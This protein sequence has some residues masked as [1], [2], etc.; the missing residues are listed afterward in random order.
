MDNRRPQLAIVS[1]IAFENLSDKFDLPNGQKENENLALYT[2]SMKEIAT[3]NK[4]HFVNAYLPSKEWFDAAGDEPLTI[5]GSQLT[6]AG[7]AKFSKLLTD[8]IF[9][10]AAAKAEAHR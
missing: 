1:P 9:G 8:Q 7:Y 6:D 3:K 10:K 4:V 2:E 5:D